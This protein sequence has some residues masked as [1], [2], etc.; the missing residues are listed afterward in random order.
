MKNLRK[1]LRS[2]LCGCLVLLMLAALTAC[3]GDQSESG[4]EEQSEGQN[5]GAIVVRERIGT[6]PTT[7]S[8]WGVESSGGDVVR[9]ALYEKLLFKNVEEGV[10]ENWLA[11]S[12]EE[13]SKTE[14]IVKIYDYITDTEGNQMTAD[15]IVFSYEMAIEAGTVTTKVACLDSVTKEGD[16]TVKFLLKDDPAAGAFESCLAGV[17]CVTKASWDASGDDMALHPVG[18]SH[19]KLEDCVSGSSW[20]FVKQDNY[21]QT[22]ESKRASCASGNADEMVLSVITDTSASAVAL[23]SGQV[24]VSMI[25]ATD[26]PNFIN[27]DGTAKDGYVCET[28][29]GLSVEMYFTCCEESPTSDIN[30]RKAIAYCLDREAIGYAL[31][32]KNGPAMNSIVATNWMDGDYG[33]TADGYFTQD[34]DLAR[35]YLSKSNY[36][37]ETLRVMVVTPM[38]KAGPLIEA[39]LSEI[40]IKCE[41]LNYDRATFNSYANDA[42]YGNYDIVVQNIGSHRTDPWLALG[43]LNGSG[44]EGGL[45]RL[46]VE[47]AKLDELY[48]GIRSATL[49]SPENLKTLSDYVQEQCYAVGLYTTNYYWFGNSDIFEAFGYDASSNVCLSSCSYK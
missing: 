30:L 35:E 47:D 1:V 36:S 5:E 4:G 39:Y 34:Y 37:G 15:D 31:Y 7:L 2:V 14:Y 27:D 46:F 21:W 23:E 25:A 22:D 44:Y 48:N 20:T 3:G 12:I 19:Y 42:A 40:G 38:A 11:E 33:Q 6:D 28:V 9:Q 16:Y 32:G 8:P 13:V 24:D 26:A 49:Y 18:T 10:Y 45:N 29:G 43:Y 41:L 17:N